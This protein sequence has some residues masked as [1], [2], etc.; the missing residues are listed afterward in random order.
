MP[1]AK[2]QSG[3]M[4]RYAIDKLRSVNVTMVDANRFLKLGKIRTHVDGIGQRGKMTVIVELKTTTRTLT[5]HNAIYDVPCIKQP[6]VMGLK[7]TEATH[8]QLQLGWT[9]RAYRDTVQSQNVVG[10]IILVATDGA[11]VVRLDEAFASKAFWDRSLSATPPV[12][13]VKKVSYSSL[14]LWPGQEGNKIVKQCCG[15]TATT[16]INRRIQMFNCGAGAVA[17]TL[18]KE[19]WSRAFITKVRNAIKAAGG[20]TPWLVYRGPVSWKVMP[21]GKNP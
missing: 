18:P 15:S 10:L 4:C 7:N 12:R 21:L 1:N 16:L 11:K 5:A 3:K 2:S 17:T 6:V 8:H 20:T 9:V 14:Q 19:K 13:P